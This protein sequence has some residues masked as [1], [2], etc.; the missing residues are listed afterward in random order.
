MYIVC[1]TRK[2]CENWK[3]IE[4]EGMLDIGIIRDRKRVKCLIRNVN[5]RH[6]RHM[7]MVLRGHLLM[8]LVFQLAKGEIRVW[9]QP[10][11]TKMFHQH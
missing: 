1:E 3:E 2:W 5:R 8:G 6:G 4:M 9:L 7:C 10:N 11:K